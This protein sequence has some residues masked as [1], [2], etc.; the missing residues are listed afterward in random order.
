MENEHEDHDAGSGPW[1]AMCSHALAQ[2]S[3]GGAV[4]S[5]AGAGAAG[6]TL[7]NGN[8]LSG[9]GVTRAQYVECVEPRHDSKQ[10]GH[11]SAR[12]SKLRGVAQQ[13]L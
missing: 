5:S 11:A 6:S 4:G 13:R 2:G 9:T 7:S 3:S 10:D 8:T 12:Q 1:M